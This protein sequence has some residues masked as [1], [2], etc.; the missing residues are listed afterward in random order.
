MSLRHMNELDTVRDA[1]RDVQLQI[2]PPPC[3]NERTT[4]Q[5]FPSR[6][7]HHRT[8]DGTNQLTGRG[9]RIF[10]EVPERCRKKEGRRKATPTVTHV[11][12]SMA[13]PSLFFGAEE[14]LSDAGKLFKGFQE[15]LDQLEA[16]NKQLEAMRP[17][18]QYY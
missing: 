7:T 1:S 17:H 3:C 4:E 15:R 16:K 6:T 18:I 9:L 2:L 14:R 10:G 12:V 5:K 8:Q 13:S 11:C